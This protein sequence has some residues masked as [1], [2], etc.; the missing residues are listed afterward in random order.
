M[1]WMLCRVLKVSETTLRVAMRGGDAS[2]P[3][4]PQALRKGDAVLMAFTELGWGRIC[5]PLRCSPWPEGLPEPEQLCA[6]PGS[7][8]RPL[9]IAVRG[10]W[11]RDPSG[12]VCERALLRTKKG[13]LVPL[14]SYA[15]WRLGDLEGQDVELVRYAVVDGQAL[16]VLTEDTPVT[17]PA[18]MEPE[19]VDAWTPKVSD[20]EAQRAPPEPWTAP[21]PARPAAAPA[22]APPEPDPPESPP[23]PPSLGPLFEGLGG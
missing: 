3:R 7:E 14:L 18:P 5:G 20:R 10:D 8:T 21:A 13:E 9:R 11:V 1:A 12:R 15:G 4:P 2:V 16:Y 17:P 6:A 23:A 19:V 22:Q